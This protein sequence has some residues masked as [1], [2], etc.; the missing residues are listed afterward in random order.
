MSQIVALLPLILHGAIFFFIIGLME[1][2]HQLHHPIGNM[3]VTLLAFTLTFY[4]LPHFFS[5]YFPNCPYRTALSRVIYRRDTLLQILCFLDYVLLYICQES[6]SQTLQ[7]PPQNMWDVSRYGKLR[8]I[9]KL[10]VSTAD[11]F[12]EY[13]HVKLIPRL[14]DTL[15]RM[16]NPPLE[17]E[18]LA[19]K[20]P[21]ALANILSIVLSSPSQIRA[22]GVLSTISKHIA[23][24]DSFSVSHTACE[25]IAWHA[26]RDQ[27]WNLDGEGG[28]ITVMLLVILKLLP[29]ASLDAFRQGLSPDNP[30]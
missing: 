12:A 10:A 18:S 2:T 3:L 16:D 24:L 20:D 13:M 27:L 23:I 1:F 21:A 30:P 15:A 11:K 4:F 26:I 8:A 29:C 22:P 14:C 6:V 9:I 25:A 19:N 7:P 17:N 28:D 5:L